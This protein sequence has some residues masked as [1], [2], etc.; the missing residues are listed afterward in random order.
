MFRAGRLRRRFFAVQLF[1]SERSSEFCGV[2]LPVVAQESQDRGN[3]IGHRV[4]TAVVDKLSRWA[5][6]PVWLAPE[7]ISWSGSL[8][9][10]TTL[11]SLGGR[12]SFSMSHLCRRDSL[13]HLS[14][15]RVAWRAIEQ[16]SQVLDCLHI[17]Y[18]LFMYADGS[19]V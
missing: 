15:G 13:L 6:E 1:N 14:S 5:V 3:P 17:K 7:L 12:A 16:V 18:I 2:P 10:S 8:D 4:A 9:H 19:G 11:I